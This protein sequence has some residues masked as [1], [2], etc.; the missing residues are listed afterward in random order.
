MSGLLI[1]W[2]WLKP[3]LSRSI[4]SWILFVLKLGV[5]AA[6]HTHLVEER[7]V[8]YWNTQRGEAPADHHVIWSVIAVAAAT[9]GEEPGHSHAAEHH[10]AHSVKT[11]NETKNVFLNQ[12]PQRRSCAN[13]TLRPLWCSCIRCGAGH[14]RISPPG[15]RLPLGRSNAAASVTGPGW[16]EHAR[17]SAAG[18]TTSF[19]H[20]GRAKVKPMLQLSEVPWESWINRKNVLPDERIVVNNDKPV[21]LWQRARQEPPQDGECLPTMT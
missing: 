12:T 16:T 15:S 17:K 6:R 11:K 1:L 19:G 14:S 13:L 18:S 3:H 21:S 8:R 9:A 5:C 4:N 7:T 10:P 2:E 20:A